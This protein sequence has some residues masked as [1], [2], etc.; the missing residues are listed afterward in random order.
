MRTADNA[1]SS[2]RVGPYEAAATRYV[3]VG[4]LLVTGVLAV[5][6]VALTAAGLARWDETGPDAAHH[7]DSIVL[8]RVSP[9]PVDSDEQSV[10]VCFG[11]ILAVGL[12][13]AAM[14]VH[15]RL[16]RRIGLRPEVGALLAAAVWCAPSIGFW[17]LW[18][19]A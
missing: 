1:P 10:A 6:P 4:L 17:L 18:P 16:R 12:A 9:V 8:G 19:A 5:G 15:R 13:I 11:L 7:A 14:V 2:R 3:W